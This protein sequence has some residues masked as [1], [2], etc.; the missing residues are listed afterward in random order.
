M[1]I[2]V[3]RRIL[4]FSLNQNFIRKKMKTGT[5]S[6]ELL[7]SRESSDGLLTNRVRDLDRK[8]SSYMSYISFSLRRHQHDHQSN[9]GG[10]VILNSLSQSKFY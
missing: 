3:I 5:R 9:E 2:G 7:N 8:Y 1:I 10:A 4:F 6:R